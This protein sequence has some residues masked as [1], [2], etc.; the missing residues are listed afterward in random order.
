MCSFSKC[1]LD[2]Y[3]V[4]GTVLVTKDRIRKRM[5][6]IL[7]CGAIILEDKQTGRH[8]LQNVFSSGMISSG[9]L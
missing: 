5:D 6:T 4:P 9:I 7:G 8:F 2:T 1:F 3:D